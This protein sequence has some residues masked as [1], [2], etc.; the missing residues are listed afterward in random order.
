M[1][2]RRNLML[3]AALSSLA[4]ASPVLADDLPNLTRVK[5]DRAYY[6]GGNDFYVPPR[7]LL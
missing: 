1:L 4:I 3:F 6:I 7:V 5:V 2:T